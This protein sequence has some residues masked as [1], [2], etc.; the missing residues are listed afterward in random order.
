MSVPVQITFRNLDP[1][2]AVRRRV[3]ERVEKLCRVNDRAVNCRV[4]VRAPHRHHRNGRFFEVRIELK[5]PG[6]PI[7][8]TDTNQDLY[9]A[10][11]DA[12]GAIERRLE[13]SEQRRRGD[14]KSHAAA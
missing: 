9:V 8:A 12:F 3:A 11:H 1:S 4:V 6:R 5:V 2:L 7:V 13:Q 10:V 14:V